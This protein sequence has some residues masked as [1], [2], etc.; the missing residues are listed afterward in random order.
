[1]KTYGAYVDGFRIAQADLTKE[2]YGTQA[3]RDKIRHEFARDRSIPVH[4]ITLREVDA[5][6]RWNGERNE[7][8]TDD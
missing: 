4:Y 3:T 2:Q 8:L 7:R 1:M 6:Y 5:R